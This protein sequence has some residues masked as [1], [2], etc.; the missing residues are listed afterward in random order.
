MIEFFPEKSKQ[1][2]PKSQLLRLEEERFVQG[3]CYFTNKIP[4]FMYKILLAHIFKSFF[5]NRVKLLD[6]FKNSGVAA[7]MK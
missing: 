4:K 6:I 2:F 1:E 7:M 5:L 3:V